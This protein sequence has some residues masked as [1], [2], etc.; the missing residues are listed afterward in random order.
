MK[1]VARATIGTVAFGS[2][3]SIHGGHLSVP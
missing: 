1:S 2:F 3:T